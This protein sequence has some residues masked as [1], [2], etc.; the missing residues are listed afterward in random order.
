MYGQREEEGWTLIELVLGIVLLVIL[1]VAISASFQSYPAIKLDSAVRR[2][3]SD[4]RFAQQLAMTRQVRHGVVFNLTMACAVA[5]DTY[6]VFQ[7]AGVCTDTPARNPSGG[8]NLMV[9]YNTD[10]Q[11]QGVTITSPSFCTVACGGGGICTQTLEFDSLGRATDAAGTQL[12]CGTVTL[13]YSGAASRTI[14]VI[15]STGKLTY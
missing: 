13:N 4:M 8:G 10:A 12:V 9:D 11:F 1:A 2:L 15:S 14:T 6:T 5:T 3:V 7:E